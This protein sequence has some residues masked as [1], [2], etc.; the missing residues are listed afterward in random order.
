[1][2]KGNP[3]S[4]FSFR[5]ECGIHWGGDVCHLGGRLVPK[6]SLEQ[7]HSR[8]ATLWSLFLLGGG[9]WPKHSICISFFPPRKGLKL[10]HDVEKSSR[11]PV[12]A[13]GFFKARDPGGKAKDNGCWLFFC[14]PLQAFSTKLDW[15]VKNSTKNSNLCR[16]SF[17]PNSQIHLV[18]DLRSLRL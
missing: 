6:R 17:K 9:E 8:E 11:D 13:D 14:A 3:V 12:M 4:L 10:G 2:A 18:S 7:P 5:R 15:R 1:M 16:V